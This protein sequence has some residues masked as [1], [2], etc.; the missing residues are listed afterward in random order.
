MKTPHPL[1]SA[2]T[3]VRCRS[4]VVSTTVPRPASPCPYTR[5]PDALLSELTPRE[6]QLVHA[7]LSYRWTDDSAIYPSV[8]TLATRL[9]CTDRT[10]QRTL[11]QLEERGY[12]II[13]AR[14]RDDQGQTSNLYAP[15]PL[16]VALLSPL[17]ATPVTASRDDHHPPV[18]GRASERNS[19]NHNKRSD[20]T[21]HKRD[22]RC[23]RCPHTSHGTTCSRC[24][25]RESG[26]VTMTRYGPLRV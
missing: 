23:P 10:I 17:A 14:Y 6:H 22:D 26:A 25:C 15:G 12:L 4:D 2:R 24:G 11:R 18:T 5:L 16:L 19:G 21:G 7:L 8:R 20:G 3:E 1:K 13:Q 9:R